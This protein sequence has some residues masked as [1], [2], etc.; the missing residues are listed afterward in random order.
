MVKMIAPGTLYRNLPFVYYLA[1]LGVIYIAFG[2]YAERNMRTIDRLQDDLQEQRWQYMSVH[3]EVMRAGS[4]GRI[5]KSVS[6]AGL[7]APRVAPHEL[8]VHS[9]LPKE[10][11]HE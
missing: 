8:I 2:H 11:D 3:S 7:V 9:D 4:R 6:E 1:F 10:E 5:A